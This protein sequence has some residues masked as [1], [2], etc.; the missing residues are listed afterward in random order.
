MFVIH[1]EAVTADLNVHRISISNLYNDTPKVFYFAS[2]DLLL[3]EPSIHVQQLATNN[4]VL[5]IFSNF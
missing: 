3:E 5:R 1:V 4:Q 2:V